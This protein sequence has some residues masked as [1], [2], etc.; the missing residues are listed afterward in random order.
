MCWGRAGSLNA[1]DSVRV[2]AFLLGMSTARA[3][4]PPPP[5]ALTRDRP[6][7]SSKCDSLFGHSKSCHANKLT[8]CIELYSAVANAERGTRSASPDI[9]R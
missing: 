3:N 2:E 7:D 5:V 6:A 1:R 8:I 9:E 4:Y